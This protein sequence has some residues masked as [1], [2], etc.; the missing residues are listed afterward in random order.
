LEKRKKRTEL[1]SE[2]NTAEKGVTQTLG[3]WRTIGYAE[4][5]LEAGQ[6]QACKNKMKMKTTKNEHARIYGTKRKGKN[7]NREAAVEGGSCGSFF[8][9]KDKD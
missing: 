9:W 5:E 2:R 3:M 1:L 8:H 7:R 6:S 4:S